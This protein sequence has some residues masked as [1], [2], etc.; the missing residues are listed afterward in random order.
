MRKY[1]LIK[2]ITEMSESDFKE[3]ERAMDILT[4]RDVLNLLTEHLI[5]DPIEEEIDPFDVQHALDI[6][7]TNRGDLHG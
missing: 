3:I 7:E 6:E 4:G 1:E 2:A 5:D